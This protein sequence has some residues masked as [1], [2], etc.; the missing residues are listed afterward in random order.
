MKAVVISCK[1][2]WSFDIYGYNNKL[3]GDS[4]F[5]DLI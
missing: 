2:F 1:Y 3:N 4:S 5:S